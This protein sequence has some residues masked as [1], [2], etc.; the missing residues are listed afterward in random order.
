M[1]HAWSLLLLRTF[2]QHSRATL[3]YM[4]VALPASSLLPP[5]PVS[6]QVWS[7]SPDSHIR[8]REKGKDSVYLGHRSGVSQYRMRTWALTKRQGTHAHHRLEYARAI[9][10]RRRVHGRE[11]DTADVHPDTPYIAHTHEHDYS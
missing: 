6:P 2:M 10:P 4:P 8:S 11:A 1:I 7:E 9:A 5:L 3:M